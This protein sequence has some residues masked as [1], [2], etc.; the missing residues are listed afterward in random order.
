MQNQK[1]L[2]SL[3]NAKSHY[4]CRQFLKD[5]DQ[6]QQHVF[7]GSSQARLFLTEQHRNMSQFVARSVTTAPAYG[8]AVSQGDFE[9]EIQR[10]YTS[11]SGEHI[12]GI[13]LGDKKV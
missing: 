6:H 5:Y 11:A 4:S 10:P 3:K 2:R 8:S 7:T 1:I 13:G 12:I 9:D